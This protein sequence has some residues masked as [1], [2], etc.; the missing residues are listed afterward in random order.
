MSGC[1]T[2]QIELAFKARDDLESGEVARRPEGSHLAGGK[3][4]PGWHRFG[5]VHPK[6]NEFDGWQ[7]I[8]GESKGAETKCSAQ[9]ANNQL[10]RRSIKLE[11]EAD[12]DN[13]AKKQHKARVNVPHPFIVLPCQS[14]VHDQKYTRIFKAVQN[15]FSRKSLISLTNFADVYIRKV[16]FDDPCQNGA[17]LN[18]REFV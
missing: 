8:K 14:C 18:L 16:S 3:P 12:A 5:T 7:A 1:V 9:E 2:N 6:I 17:K 13:C 4:T 15:F 10:K 11:A